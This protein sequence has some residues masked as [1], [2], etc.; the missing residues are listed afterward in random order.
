MFRIYLETRLSVKLLTALESWFCVIVSDADDDRTRIRDFFARK[1]CN[2]VSF[3]TKNE[4]SSRFWSSSHV[5]SE[6]ELNIVSVSTLI[7]R[8]QTTT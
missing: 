1:L 7:F 4:Y 6:D 5:K 8:C 3:A 2:I